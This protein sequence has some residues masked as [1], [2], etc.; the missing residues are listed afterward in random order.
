M[1]NPKIVTIIQELRAAIAE[2]IPSVKYITQYVNP[3]TGCKDYPA[4]A[5]F[6]D[7]EDEQAQDS[8]FETRLTLRVYVSQA[9]PEWGQESLQIMVHKVRRMI[10]RNR[11]NFGAGGRFMPGAISYGILPP[12]DGKPVF[13]ADMPYTIH[14]QDLKTEE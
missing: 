2:E 5:I 10:N 4:V 9:D 13:R 8:R 12:R 14:Y 1:P 6:T 7:R 3:E 11:R